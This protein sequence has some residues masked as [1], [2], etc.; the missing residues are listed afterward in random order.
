MPKQ[1]GAGRK[2]LP[3]KLKLANKHHGRNTEDVK[4]MVDIEDSLNPCFDKI[5]KPPTKLTKDA[6]KEWKRIIELYE[7]MGLNLL[8]DLDI[9]TLETYCESVSTWR[10]LQK[11]Y[12]DKTSLSLDDLGKITTILDKQSKT[13]SRLA[14][15]LCITPVG[16]A[17]MGA[18]LAKAP[19]KNE[20]LDVFGDDE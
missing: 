11:E 17:R 2:P 1:A 19:K 12:A 4:D 8:S 16:R 15:Q 18:V 20:I 6:K 3:A 7:K 13:V 5:K 10:T 14:E 9:F